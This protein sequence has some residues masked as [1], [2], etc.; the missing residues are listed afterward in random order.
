MPACHTSISGSNHLALGVCMSSVVSTIQGIPGNL[1]LRGYLTKVQST[2]VAD[3]ELL[4]FGVVDLVSP[5]VHHEFGEQCDRQRHLQ[6][7]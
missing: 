7:R 3:D 5:V 6:E 1:D 4:Y 2:A